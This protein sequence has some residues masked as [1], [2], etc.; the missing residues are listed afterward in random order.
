MEKIRRKVA[1]QS[2]GA[3]GYIKNGLDD[4]CESMVRLGGL[5]SIP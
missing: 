3:K 4:S 1:K 5:T 2:K